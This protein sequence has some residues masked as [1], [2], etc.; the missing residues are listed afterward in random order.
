MI[1][2]RVG[3]ENVAARP[4]QICIGLQ[5][6]FGDD[7][8]VHAA[9]AAATVVS[10]WQ[11]ARI[12]AGLPFLSGML[13]ERTLLYGIGQQGAAVAR[14][15]PMVIF[16]GT[17]SVRRTPVPSDAE[18]IEMVESLAVCLGAEFRQARVNVEYCGRAWVLEADDEPLPEEPHL[19]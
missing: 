12:N 4:F 10:H 6:G 17:V 18:A 2:H 3:L 19:S 1:Y 11:V 8:R 5:E 7:N 16:S 15:E 13:D 14:Q 9:S